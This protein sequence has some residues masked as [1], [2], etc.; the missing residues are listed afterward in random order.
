MSYLNHKAYSPVLQAIK[1]NF[2][3]TSQNPAH[4]HWQL[5]A[6][7]NPAASTAAVTFTDSEGNAVEFADAS[8][9]VLAQS[10]GQAATVVDESTKTTTGCT[11]TAGGNF[12]N[13]INLMVI[14]RLKTQPKANG[15]L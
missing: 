10:E 13:P 4:L 12:T 3:A 2:M 15:T 6:T 11:I 1:A 9:V 5:V 8:Y 7:P 14:G